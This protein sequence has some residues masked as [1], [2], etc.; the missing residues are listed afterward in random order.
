VAQAQYLTFLAANE[1]SSIM[2]LILDQLPG[3]PLPLPEIS[4]Q[5]RAMWQGEQTAL[6]AAPSEFRASQLNLVLHFGPE[7]LPSE[8]QVRFQD[9]IR[10]TQSHPGRII[11]LC[12]A[13]TELPAGE[14]LPGK[15]FTQC[16]IG[17]SQR[18]MCCC[19]ALMMDYCFSDPQSLFNQVSIWLESDLPVYHWFHRIR[20][21]EVKNRYLAF[22]KNSRRLLFD[23]AV[24]GE[25]HAALPVQEPWRLRDLADARLLPVKQ[26]IGQVLSAYSPA[27][28]A[29]GLESIQV[30]YAEGSEPAAR[31]LRR[32]VERCLEHEAF[33][34]LLP[35]PFPL[36]LEAQVIPG[37][38]LGLDFAYGN[39]QRFRWNLSSGGPHA[40]VDLFLGGQ[41]LRQCMSLRVLQ[42]EDLLSEA[43][44]FGRN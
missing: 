10:F 20:A 33:K 29:D 36:R 28:I 17:E 19:E 5:I 2:S 3:V 4:R 41:E 40:A 16:Y 1:D 31:M 26:A 38:S 24:E 13:D 27:V 11:V 12:A 42:A 25:G 39:Q 18:E 6:S 8:A 23:S 7:T 32:W 21:E 43:V 9:A 35:R 15:L 14:S 37:A 22:V 34:V 30:R 44:F